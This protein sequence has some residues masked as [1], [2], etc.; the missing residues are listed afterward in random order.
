MSEFHFMLVDANLGERV[1]LNLLSIGWKYNELMIIGVF[2]IYKD[3]PFQWDATLLGAL[4]FSGSKALPA[5]KKGIDN[6]NLSEPTTSDFPILLVEDLDSPRE[7]IRSYIEAM[8][9]SK[10]E[11]VSSAKLALE[12]LEKRPGAFSCIVTDMNMPEM[13]GADMIRHIRRDEVLHHLPVI[14]LTAYSTAENLVECI[15]AGATGFLVKPPRK[16]ALR[17][18]L[19]KARRVYY[20][21]QSP[22]L[23]SPDDAHLLEKA[24]LKSFQP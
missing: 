15:K 13:S 18:E 17:M 14:V 22:R 10:V 5:I 4:V 21:R 23:C 7:I 8:G 12:L 24:L 16:K 11:D 6:L 1:A 20:G 3:V 19:E 9:Y 2:D